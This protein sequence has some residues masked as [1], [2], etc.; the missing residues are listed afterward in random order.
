MKNA[1][2]GKSTSQKPA[3]LSSKGLK[4]QGIDAK[5]Y[6]RPKHIYSIVKKMRDKGIGFERVLDIMGFSYSGRRST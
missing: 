5:V 4:E 2:S 6:G 1:Q 3:H